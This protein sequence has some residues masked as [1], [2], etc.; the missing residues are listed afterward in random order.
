MVDFYDFFF[1][2][3]GSINKL[4]NSKNYVSR[5]FFFLLKEGL[6]KFLVIELVFFL[7]IKGG[8]KKVW[9]FMFLVD[10]LEMDYIW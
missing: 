3:V 4:E 8:E 7:R 1:L 5:I 2:W 10:F 9:V 6:F